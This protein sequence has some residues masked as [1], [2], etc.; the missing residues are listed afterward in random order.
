MSLLQKIEKLSA[1]LSKY[2][3]N[4]DSRNTD[5]LHEALG[6]I[7]SLDYLEKMTLKYVVA[8][9]IKSSQ[10]YMMYNLFYNFESIQPRGNLVRLFDGNLNYDSK[11]NDI[12]I[13]KECLF[14]IKQNPDLLEE[15]Y[16]MA[17]ITYRYEY[18]R[19]LRNTVR[20][21]HANTCKYCGKYYKSIDRHYY[22]CKIQQEMY[23]IFR[24]NPDMVSYQHQGYF[25]IFGARSD[26]NIRSKI[27]D[28]VKTKDSPNFQIQY[29]S[30]PYTEYNQPKKIL[31]PKELD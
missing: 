26:W 2:N 1:I 15:F 28:L 3:D 22:R 7:N 12:E 11:P 17:M 29:I 19:I 14:L 16:N 5:Y 23:S 27:I 24:E 30:I 8:Q 31:F 10:S 21:N 18:N 4:L 6:Y 25:C 9:S 13:L 20:K